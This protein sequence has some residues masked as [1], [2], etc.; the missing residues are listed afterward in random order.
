[1]L[2]KGQCSAKKRALQ[3]SVLC[4]GECSANHLPGI[5]ASPWRATCPASEPRQPAESYESRVLMSI[6]WA[7][8]PTAF[9]D[10]SLPN[11]E[12]RSSIASTCQIDMLRL[13]T[14]GAPPGR[15]TCPASEP[16][17]RAREVGIPTSLSPTQV[18]IPTSLSHQ[19]G[20]P[21]LLSH[22]GRNSDFAC[23]PEKPITG[24]APKVWQQDCVS[25]KTMGATCRFPHLSHTR[26]PLNPA[27]TTGLLHSI[28]R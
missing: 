23:L 28:L 11:V 17:C 19:V 5:E 15:A 26:R 2:C 12:D 6:R 1:M 18:G 24:P 10:T 16:A 21:T 20:T 14:P 9:Q 8:N 22:Q 3:R 27:L 7:L 13:G 25:H 4:K